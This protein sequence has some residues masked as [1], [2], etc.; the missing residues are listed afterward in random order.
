MTVQ[1]SDVPG[2]SQVSAGP[3]SQAGYEAYQRTFVYARASGSARI[4][5]V[6]SEVLL[7]STLEQAVL[8]F[9]GAMRTFQAK[10]GRNAL[11]SALASTA[12]VKTK[13]VVVG[14]LKTPKL[15][16]HAFEVPL[17]VKGKTSRVYG[18]LLYLQLDRTIVIEI[19]D[20][21]RPVGA[22]SER[23]VR[24]SVSHIST[25]LRPLSLTPPTITGTA[26]QGQTLTAVPGTWNV[27]ATDAYQWQRCDATG[28]N[29]VDI[30]GAASSTYA[31]SAGDAGATLRVV[32][33]GTARFGTVAAQSAVTAAVT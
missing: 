5:Y 12:H 19:V 25:A 28:A 4:V 20:G 21:L 24:R 22:A 17:S 11:A 33:T 26:Q 32:D 18:T 27:P 9:G 7:G 16:D 6:R 8:D 1:A 31:V 29:C 3:D 23:L 2:A 10:S 13:A 14:K 15:G 30:S